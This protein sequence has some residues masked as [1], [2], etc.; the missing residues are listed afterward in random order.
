[1][2]AGSSDS[3]EAGLVPPVRY[4]SHDEDSAHWLDFPFRSG[5]IVIST[6]SERHNLG[7]DDVCPAGLP[8]P[9]TPE[10]AVDPVA[11]V[12]LAGQPQRRRVRPSVR[13]G[14]SAVHQDPHAPRRVALAMNGLPTS[15][16]LG[17]HWTWRFHST[18]RGTTSTGS[19]SGSGPVNPPPQRLLFHGRHCR[20]G[21][22]TGSPGMAIATSRWTHSQE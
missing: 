12:G 16:W 17:I 3:T 4:R 20:S 13:A 1:M 19:D 6:R 15:S 11:L 18:T 7:A 14:T 8:D 22:R 10:Q 2:R 9:T 5:D 21:C